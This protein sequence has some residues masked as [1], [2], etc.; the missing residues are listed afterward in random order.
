MFF[1]FLAGLF[2]LSAT[3]LHASGPI[4]LAAEPGPAP[5]KGPLSDIVG[6]R[7]QQSSL[8]HDIPLLTVTQHKIERNSFLFNALTSAGISRSDAGY[9]IKAGEPYLDMKS[10]KANTSFSIEW[11]RGEANAP[12]LS[13]VEIYPDPITKLKFTRGTAE[14][15][16]A[17]QTKYSVET[18]EAAFVGV[19]TSSL[20]ESASEAGMDFQLISDLAEVFAWQIDFNREVR[21]GDR[22]RLVVEQ[23]LVNGR[24]YQWGNILVAE[25]EKEGETHKGIRYPEK[26]PNAGFFDERGN[27]LRKMFLRAPLKYTRITSSFKMARFHPIL[28]KMRPHLGIDYGAPAGT[29]ILA[30]GDGTITYAGWAG[31][32]GTMVRIR[33]NSV[34]SSAYLHMQKVAKNIKAGTKVRQRDVVGYVGMSGLATGPHLHFSFFINNKYVDPAGMRFPSADPVPSGERGSFGAVANRMIAKLP[35]WPSPLQLNVTALQKQ[36]ST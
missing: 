5:L 27:S 17:K 30:I 26:G 16:T 2:S 22:W 20:W 24:H 28:K 11:I 34:Y 19:V 25:Y 32:S 29:P 1:Y 12:V 21:T 10:I 6:E 31:D 23:Q 35:R 13:A 14:S 4:T 36:P 9:I 3:L 18:R 33:H 15:W 7:T 8:S